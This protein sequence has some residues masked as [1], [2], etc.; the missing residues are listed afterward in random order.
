MLRRIV[1][2]LVI[3]TAGMAVAGAAKARHRHQIDATPFSHAPCSVL[4][5]R[6]C[7]P[8]F[9]SV[10]NHGPCI[11]EIDYPYGENLQLTIESVPPDD[12]KAKYVKPDHDLDTI[13]DLFAE[14]RSCWSPPPADAAKQGMQI[15]VRFSFKRSGEIIASPR[16]TFATAGVSADIRDTYLKAINASL[17]ACVPLKFSGDLAGALAGRPI[18][19]RYVD[20]RDLGTQSGT[21]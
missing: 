8:T 16:L 19:I 11:P 7:T 2:W 20:N 13:G 15:T 1:I 18:A 10:F 21:P 4:S 3:V 14:L 9:C 5:G 17:D 12:D 6:P